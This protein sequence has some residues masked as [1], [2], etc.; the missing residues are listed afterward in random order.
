MKKDL[1]DPKRTNEWID[2]FKTQGHE[3]LAVDVSQKMIFNR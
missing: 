1:A 2:H 3:A